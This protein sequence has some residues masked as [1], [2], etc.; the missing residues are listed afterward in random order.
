MRKALGLPEHQEV[1]AIT[2]GYA[3]AEFVRKGVKQRRSLAEI[4]RFI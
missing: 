4:M 1:F 3:C 2:L